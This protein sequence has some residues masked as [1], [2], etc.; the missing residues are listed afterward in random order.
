MALNKEQLKQ[1]I[2]ALLTNM[3]TKEQISDEEYAEKFSKA[4][5]DYVK[6]ASIKYISGLLA[7]NGAVSGTFNGKLE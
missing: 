4:I 1:D 3:R 5:D 6:A 2:L 7:P